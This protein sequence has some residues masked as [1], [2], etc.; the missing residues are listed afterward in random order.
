[1]SLDAKSKS[2]TELAVSVG[3]IVLVGALFLSQPAVAAET[4]V[5]VYKT[6]T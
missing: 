1:M 4:S 6:P 2:R 5:T 3:L